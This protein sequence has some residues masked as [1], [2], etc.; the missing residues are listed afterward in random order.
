MTDTG[1]PKSLKCNS[2]SQEVEKEAYHMIQK[3]GKKSSEEESMLIAERYIKYIKELK[4]YNSEKI[5][6]YNTRSLFWFEVSN[7]IC[8][9]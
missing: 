9:L 8:N 6:L 2:Y 3:Y 7:F 1:Y 4:Y 5:T